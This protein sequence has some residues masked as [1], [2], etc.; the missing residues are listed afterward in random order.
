MPDY[1]VVHPYDPAPSSG[2]IRRTLSNPSLMPDDRSSSTA[3]QR[4][5]SRAI[6][7]G[8]FLRVD[9]IL[10]ALNLSN[11]KKQKPL[12]QRT[13]LPRPFMNVDIQLNRFDTNYHLV[14]VFNFW[15]DGIKVRC[16]RHILFLGGD[17]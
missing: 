8:L 16:V 13:G 9:S 3:Q 17:Q 10:P 14:T 1:Q 5:A 6:S 2:S 11:R 4:D 7:D 12:Q 15:I